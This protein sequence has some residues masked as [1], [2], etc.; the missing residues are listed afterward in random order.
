MLSEENGDEEYS[1]DDDDV[2]DSDEDLDDDNDEEEDEDED[3]Q[4]N[5]SHNITKPVIA[6]SVSIYSGL[7]E[8]FVCIE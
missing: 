6:R 4:A 8:E 7:P 3:D 2:S 5:T 1:D